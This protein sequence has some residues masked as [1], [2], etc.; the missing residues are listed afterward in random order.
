[1]VRLLPG[2]HRVAREHRLAGQQ[3]DNLCGAYWGATLLRTFGGADVRAEDVAVLAG[4]LLPVGDPSSW[5]PPGADNRI[6]YRKPLPVASDPALSGTSAP[7]LAWAI[8]RA[9]A[10]RFVCIPLRASWTAERVQD[11]LTL[12]HEH[13][14]WEAIPVC[15]VRTGKLWGSRPALADVLA[16]LAGNDVTPPPPDWD[17]G[18]FVSV[19]GTVS[20]P[21]R[22]MA[23][24]RDS[25]PGFGWDMHYLQPF[26]S[27]ASA[28]ERGDGREGGMLLFTEAGHEGEVA[29]AARARGLDVAMWDNGTPWR[30]PGE[31]V[32]EGG[33]GL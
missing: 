26:D 20:G 1:M 29:E 8:E 10:G 33:A 22:A 14:G 18:H 11:V 9:S 27:L 23:L 28:L 21:E 16:Y 24:V 4:S 3:L 5:V 17:C 30:P 2:A 12:C 6:D 32:S 7:G 31:Q 13:P 15:N 19:A 25:Y